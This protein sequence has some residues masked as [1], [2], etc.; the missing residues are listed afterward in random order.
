M[1]AETREAQPGGVS[2][3]P[4]RRRRSR[5]RPEWLL[6]IAAVLCAHLVFFLFFKTEYLEFFRKEIAGDD[7]TSDFVVMDRPFALIPY[8][9]GAEPPAVPDPV[10][11]DDGEQV[12]RSVLDDIGEPAAE[13]EPIRRSGGAGSDGRPGPRRSVV[14]PKPLFIPWPA[15][16]DGAPDDIRGTVDLMLYVDESGIVKEIRVARGLPHESLN[17]TAVEAASRIRFIPGEEK[18]APAAMWVRLSIGF[19]PR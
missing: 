16:P 18:G 6:I 8:L 2:V 7:G 4:V 10:A 11:A 13:I 19:Q 5:S 9:E 1:K 17:R 12:Q 15:Y 3:L 14:E